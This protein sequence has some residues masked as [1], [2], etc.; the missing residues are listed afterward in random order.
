ML[1][2]TI[3]ADGVSQLEIDK[4]VLLTRREK[5]RKKQSMIEWL[6]DRLND[7]FME[8]LPIEN[9]KELGT[10]LTYLI[11]SFAYALFLAV[12]VYFYYSGYHIARTKS[13]ISLNKNE[14][15][16]QA[17]VTEVS[18]SWYGTYDGYWLGN[19]NC[20]ALNNNRYDTCRF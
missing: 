12:F 11:G 17:V 3:D 13:F 10:V 8:N 15:D 7:I 1:S 5:N 16:C 20:F 18:G 9:I 2:N 19:G 14:G 6:S 4:D